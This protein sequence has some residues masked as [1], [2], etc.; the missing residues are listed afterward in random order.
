LDSTNL[1]HPG[2]SRGHGRYKLVQ[3]P[4]PGSLSLSSKSL[5]AHILHYPP[6]PPWNSFVI[7]TAVINT[8]TPSRSVDEVASGLTFEKWNPAQAVDMSLKP[9][10]LI[11]NSS[12]LRAASFRLDKVV[13]SQ[14]EAAVRSGMRTRGAG[15]RQL[16][17]MGSES[18]VLNV[19]LDTEFR[20]SVSEWVIVC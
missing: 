18:F 14:L 1:Y 10:A 17:G 3:H 19:D 20:F 12:Q 6:P 7:G 11:I 4:H 13:P 2:I 9:A 16:R 8:Y 15:M 5:I